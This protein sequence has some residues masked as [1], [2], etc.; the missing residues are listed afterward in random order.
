MVQT[1]TLANIG[2][3]V[4]VATTL[5][6][7]W[8]RGHSRMHGTLTPSIF[9]P[10]FHDA[11]L[12]T[13]RP[14]LEME[15]IYSFK[16]DA[17]TLSREPLPDMSDELG[18]LYVMQ[19]YG[20]PTRLLDWT[21]N[22]LVALYFAVL[23]NDEED[24]EVWAMLPWALNEA[25]GIGWAMPLVEKDT[26]VRYLIAEP[27]WNGSYEALAAHHGLEQ[28]QLRPVAFLPYRQ[29]PRM[30]AQASTFTIHPLPQ[31]AHRIE[32]CLTDEKH[33]VRYRIPGEAKFD[34][35]QKLAS[36]GINHRVLFP[37]Y[38]GLSRHVIRQ[39]EIVAYGP[40]PPPRCAGLWQS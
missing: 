24:G 33:L 36:L 32:D 4:E 29:F 22:L 9:R 11:V 3:A 16:R 18:W 35:R 21:E 5:S 37:D 10:A 27:F 25:A 15:M 31:E 14:A 23:S 1:Y 34:L 28:P 26:R 13:V 8:F 38:E 2:D 39:A 17:P 30:L 19:H 6:Q 20:A 7:S 12:R 40:P